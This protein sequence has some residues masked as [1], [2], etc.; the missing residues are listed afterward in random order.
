LDSRQLS[1]SSNTERR[2]AG[3]TVFD[4]FEDI[5]VRHHDDKSGVAAHQTLCDR[6]RTKLDR[7]RIQACG[8]TNMVQAR[9]HLVGSPYE[10]SDPGID[11]RS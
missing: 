6:A 8:A 1:Q 10:L 11:G 9:R 3:K 5:P 4:S 2:G 7:G